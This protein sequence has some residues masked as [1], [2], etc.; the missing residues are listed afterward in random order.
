MVLNLQFFKKGH[1]LAGLFI[2]FIQASLLSL[3]FLPGSL[4]QLTLV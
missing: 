4:L 1:N 2:A 3:L